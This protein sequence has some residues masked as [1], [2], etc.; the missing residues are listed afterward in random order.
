MEGPAI[1]YELPSLLHHLRGQNNRNMK[2][3][4]F[5]ALVTGALSLTADLIALGL[6]FSQI[7]SGVPVPS[8]KSNILI[9]FFMIYGW[10]AI[11]W[12][13][14]R[15][16]W[17]GYISQLNKHNDLMI[18]INTELNSNL[19]H[20]TSPNLP[21]RIGSTVAALGLL[22]T[23]LQIMFVTILPPFNHSLFKSEMEFP[24]VVKQ[25]L[26]I[27]FISLISLAM[28]G[29]LIFFALG[30]LMPIIYP[31]MNTELA[32]EGLQASRD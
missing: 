6:F 26:L 2:K 10:V 8:L 21:R 29:G 28:I 9:A 32:V 4:G 16:H 3:C 27:A 25:V 7:V 17:V 15:K 14:I 19:L 11:A 22:L 12:V 31:D 1:S 20:L 18:H 30:F 23:P 24:D 13:L 5:F